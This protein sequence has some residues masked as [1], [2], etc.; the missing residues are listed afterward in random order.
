MKTIII[1]ILLLAQIGCSES[2]K[3]ISHIKP[4]GTKVTIEMFEN[5]YVIMETKNEVPDGKFSYFDYNNKQI[6][7][8]W[9]QNNKTPYYVRKGWEYMIEGE[10]VEKFDI[11]NSNKIDTPKIEF[12]KFSD[13]TSM[14]KVRYFYP[15]D[16]LLTGFYS[17]G[18]DEHFSYAYRDALSFYFNKKNK[19]KD[20]FY[21]FFV[22]HGNGNKEIKKIDSIP[23]G[24]KNKY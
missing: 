2:K 1:S 4:D 3:K 15:T 17:G 24:F 13:S 20:S 9:Y 6:L 5:G 12:I 11:L 22:F 16:K 23:V 8:E 10:T 14:L 18:Q 7:T 19:I 21:M